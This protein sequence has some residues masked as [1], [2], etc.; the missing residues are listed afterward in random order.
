MK[1]K[2]PFYLPFIDNS[3]S[4]EINDTLF[5]TGWLTTG[6]KVKLFEGMIKSYTSC[7]EV[8]CTNSWSSGMNLILK[9]LDL[10]KDDEIII[11]VYTYA[12]TAQVPISY[13]C[14]IIFVDVDD[15]KQIDIKQLKQVINKNTKAIVPVDIGGMPCDYNKIISIA[16]NASSIYQADNEI[17]EKI[18]R[19]IVISD[20][21]HS[22]GS[23]YKNRK[24]GSIADFTIF[25]F[26]SVKNITTGEGGAV[27][28]NLDDDK[29]EN[30]KIY[31]EM[32][33][34]GLYG[35]SKSA[36]EKIEDN[37]W[38]YD[39]VNNG[40]KTNMTDIL[41]SIGISQLKIYNQI[42]LP[43]RLHIYNQYNNILSSQDKIES[44]SIYE[45]K[46]NK[47]SMHLYQ[48]QLDKNVEKHRNKIMN[49]LSEKNI[50]TNVHYKPLTKFTY[51]KKLGYNNNNFPNSN[52]ISNRTISLPI[53]NNLSS[54]KIDYVIDSLEKALKV[55]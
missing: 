16:E 13:G 54:I 7:K 35:Q 52:N 34:L 38:E 46:D 17:Q 50:G 47:S 40:I 18:G 48:I 33:I 37:N 45:N 3:I 23:I 9:W 43:Q 39:I 21:A 4:R 1:L 44:T 5:R 30:N 10:K 22:I 53:Y 49:I 36:I 27:C 19:P 11:P 15:Y 6:P 26:H 51:F 12:A 32:S 41:A 29:F 31:N 55:I 42:L 20:A 28:I 8:L 2:V 14:K 25:S 24:T